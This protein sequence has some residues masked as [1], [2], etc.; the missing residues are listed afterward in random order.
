MS[1]QWTPLRK[2]GCISEFSIIFVFLLLYFGIKFVFFLGHY[3]L[4]S[5]EVIGLKYRQGFIGNSLG[6]DGETSLCAESLSHL[7]ARPFPCGQSFFQLA[8]QSPVTTGP[9]KGQHLGR[10]WL[11]SCHVLGSLGGST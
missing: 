8:S 2:L 10:G 4:L 1:L 3:A 9:G 5:K 7:Q 11:C 6:R